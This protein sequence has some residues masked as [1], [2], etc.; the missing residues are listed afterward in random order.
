MFQDAY[1]DHLKPGVKQDNWC[2]LCNAPL[3]SYGLFPGD[4][5]HW[6]EDDITKFEA[7]NLSTN[8]DQVLVVSHTKRGTVSSPSP[9]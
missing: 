2:A 5:L 1:L 7:T 6:A 4:A 9:S 3:Q 8:P